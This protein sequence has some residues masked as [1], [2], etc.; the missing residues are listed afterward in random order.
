LEW[1]MGQGSS[2]FGDRRNSE[3]GRTSSMNEKMCALK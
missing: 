1:S 2:G 3:V